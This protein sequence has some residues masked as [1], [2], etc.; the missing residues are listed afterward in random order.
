MWASSSP[1]TEIGY[2]ASHQH[3]RLRYRGRRRYGV[4]ATGL[5]EWKA[6][7]ELLQIL[8]SEDASTAI[9]IPKMLIRR[10]WPLLGQ[11]PGSNKPNRRPPSEGAQIPKTKTRGRRCP[12][13]TWGGGVGPPRCRAAFS[14]DGVRAKRRWIFWLPWEFACTILDRSVS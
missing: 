4:Q 10:K 11:P 9:T 6:S 2:V 1:Y 7:K 14:T 5:V 8:R 13:L 12:V 3:L